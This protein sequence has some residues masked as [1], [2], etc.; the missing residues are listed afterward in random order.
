MNSTARDEELGYN[1]Y[2]PYN[3]QPGSSSNTNYN[4]NNNQYG[5]A[6]RWKRDLETH[7][8]DEDSVELS[9]ET[10]PKSPLLSLRETSSQAETSQ[11]ET[12]SDDDN[13]TGIKPSIKVPILGRSLPQDSVADS[14]KSARQ[15]STNDP[16]KTRRPI[17][18]GVVYTKW[19]AISAG[20]LIG[21]MQCQL[22]LCSHCSQCKSFPK[23]Q[24]TH[25]MTHSFFSRNR[26]HTGRNY[27]PRKWIRITLPISTIRK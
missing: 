22:T 24:I 18:T 4:N 13:D 15:V 1:P 12:P 25:I 27:Y 6:N 3:S 5:S 8:G 17:E 7:D 26:S 16:G 2:N 10:D 21:G 9:I 14:P 23:L 19:G 11:E 20:R